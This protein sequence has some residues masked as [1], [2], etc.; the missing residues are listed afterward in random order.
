MIELTQC[1]IVD[2]FQEKLRKNGSSKT[3]TYN[4]ADPTHFEKGVAKFGMPFSL[5]PDGLNQLDGPTPENIEVEWHD[6]TWGVEFTINV[7]SIPYPVKGRWSRS[8]G[9][10]DSEWADDTLPIFFTIVKDIILQSGIPDF[11]DQ[12]EC[13]K[14]YR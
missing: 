1:Q 12:P 11:W 14:I 2:L 13:H 10:G 5:N 7:P 4:K 6:C 9:G 3:G 8:F